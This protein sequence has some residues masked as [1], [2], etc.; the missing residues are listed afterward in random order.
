MM[1]NHLTHLVE[2]IITAVLSPNESPQPLT[3]FSKTKMSKQNAINCGCR[4]WINACK[5]R[6]NIDGLQIVQKTL[7]QKANGT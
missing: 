1:A 2:V 7:S 6:N 5:P 4:E 3:N